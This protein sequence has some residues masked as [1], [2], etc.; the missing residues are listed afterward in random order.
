MSNKSSDNAGEG[1]E[2]IVEKILQMQMR[3][4]K[5]YYL[6]KW[7]GYPESESTWEP[8]ENC[9][10]SDLIDEFWGK[11]LRSSTESSTSN[12][13]DSEDEISISV[14]LLSET[15][16]VNYG[17]NY[18]KQEEF[19]D[20]S[21]ESD[22]SDENLSEY[23]SDYTYGQEGFSSERETHFTLANLN[24]VATDM[25]EDEVVGITVKSDELYYLLKCHVTGKI[26]SLPS[27]VASVRYPQAVIKFLETKI[28]FKMPENYSSRIGKNK[29]NCDGKVVCLRKEA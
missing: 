25:E 12:G 26:Y 5:R 18:E 3:E 1:E 17:T 2:Y 19:A 10:C 22:T 9:H 8:E 4:N 14:P 6:I 23:N 7:E 16:D 20:I 29:W 28:T 13:F 15:S 11:I 24:I 27:S 21:E